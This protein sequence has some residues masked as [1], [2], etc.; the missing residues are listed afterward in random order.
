VIEIGFL[1]H[2]SL[3]F[4]GATGSLVCDPWF[5]T[6]PIYGNS[7]IKYPVV[8]AELEDAFRGASHVYISHHHEDHFHV[9]SLDRLS[10]DVT[11]YIPSFEYVTHPRGRSMERTLRAMGF[12]KVQPLASYESVEIDLGEPVRL[13]LVPSATSRWHDWENSG[14]IVETADWNAINLNDNLADKDLLAEIRKRCPSLDVAFVPGSPSTEYPGAFDFTVREKISLGRKKRDEISQAKLIIEEIKPTY[15]VPIASDIAW[16]RPQDQFRNYSDKPTPTSFAK[17]LI[18]AG[19]VGRERFVMLSPG[20]FLDPISGQVS[21]LA[22]PVKYAG[23]RRRLRE[24]G[25]DYGQLI[26]A[27]DRYAAQGVFDPD[28]YAALIE[29]LNAYIPPF[30]RPVAPVRIDFLVVGSD[31]Q[32]LR[33]MGVMADGENVRVEDLPVDDQACDQEIVVPEGV[34]AETFGGKVLRRDLFGLC[35]NRQLKPFRPEVAALRYFITYYFDRG[36]LSPW[37]RISESDPVAN[38]AEMRRLAKDFA[39]RFPLQRLQRHYCART[40]TIACHEA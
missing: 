33:R 37:L 15:L 21:S 1:G 9:P 12:S 40:P 25:A 32:A 23:F 38:Q 29:Q 27:H 19:L 14:I 20:D 36:D 24:I 13:T 10:R 39:P 31:A 2:A 34:W 35:V 8:P 5:S 26:D 28:A 6:V 22:G 7:A 18:G 4:R 11:I 3:L 30:P 16:H 17:R